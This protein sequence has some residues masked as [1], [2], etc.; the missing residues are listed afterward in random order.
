MSLIQAN[1]KRR[2]QI[3]TN[4]L[5]V[6][7]KYP[8]FPTTCTSQRPAAFFVLKNSSSLLLQT[9]EKWNNDNFSKSL[10]AHETSV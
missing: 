10:I 4:F 3:K 8:N 9:R 7:E 6:V 5:L 1:Y 2:L